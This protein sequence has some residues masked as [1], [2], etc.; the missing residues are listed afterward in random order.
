M[1]RDK[2]EQEEEDL[3]A[4]EA[5]D[6]DVDQ[7]ASARVHAPD[8]LGHPEEEETEEDK[9]EIPDVEEGQEEPTPEEAAQFESSNMDEGTGPKPEEAALSHQLPPSLQAAQNPQ[10][11]RLQQYMQQYNQ[12]QDQQRRG[13]MVNALAAAGGKI[14]QSMAGKYSGNFTPDQ[15]GN[16]ML[17]QMN[18]QPL[19]N[20]EQGMAVQGAGIKLSSELEANDP[21]SNISQA[22]RQYFKQRIMPK[23]ANGQP[24]LKAFPNI[25]SYSASDLQNL[26]KGIGRPVQTKFQKVNMINKNTGEKVLG[27]FNPT[28]QAFES[29]GRQL[30]P[31]QWIEN[32]RENV[33]TNPGTGE[34]SSF[35]GATGKITGTLTGPTG[36]IQPTAEGQPEVELSEDDLNARQKNNLKAERTA[37]LKD[38]KVERND[39]AVASKLHQLLTQGDPDDPKNMIEIERNINL[40]SGAS[41]RVPKDQLDASGGIRSWEQRMKQAA[42]TA[43]TGGL[44]DENNQFL[45]D[46]AD[47]MTQASQNAI[48]A[49]AEPHINALHT[50]IKGASKTQLAK[51]LGVNQTANPVQFQPNKQIVKKGYNKA[52][53]QTQLIYSD[54]SKEI[55]NGQQ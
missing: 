5:D 7:E 31:N 12:L 18:Q 9:A 45:L 34:K 20:F 1:A 55:V 46:T 10:L 54:G 14:G 52:T 6:S 51:L 16:K 50:G 39:L 38:A 48:N 53:D 8:D 13:S 4:D 28:T 36:T 37:F 29:N 32:Y 43:A 49:Y 47:R 27:T 41:G 23:D 24:D 33:T 30:D 35:S 17:A 21:N 2:E 15:E 42:Q 25:D 11:S 22:Y 26:I 3:A 40:L 44:T 19:K